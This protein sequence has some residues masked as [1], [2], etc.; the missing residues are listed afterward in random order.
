MVIQDPL[1]ILGSRDGAV[2]SQSICLLSM[3]P[4]FY[5]GLCVICGLRLSLVLILASRG[6]SLS[7]P[8]SP[9]PQKP[10]FLNSNLIWIIVKHSLYH[11][12]LAQ[13]IVQAL[14]MSLTLKKITLLYFTLLKFTYFYFTSCACCGSKLFL[15]KN[16]QTSLIFI[17]HC[18]RLWQ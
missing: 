15:V 9:F 5:S 1:N 11:E 6:F 3:W 4:R 16:F 12:P 10:T 8:V 17:S 14:T 13:E 7:P 2:V 18:R